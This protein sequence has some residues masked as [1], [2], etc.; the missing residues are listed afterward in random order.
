MRLLVEVKLKKIDE[1]VKSPVREHASDAGI[2]IFAFE[3]AEIKPLERKLVRTGLFIE[4]PH[5]VEA[6]LRPKSGL[7]LNHGITLLNTPATID[8]SYRGEIKVLL[9]NLGEKPFKVEK[10]SKICQI[11]FNSIEH[12]KIIEVKELESSSRGEGG[13]GSTGLK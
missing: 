11:V 2:D 5:G 7:A 8:A 4:L 12:P 13:F 6:Q 3:Q 1:S 10:G 9:I